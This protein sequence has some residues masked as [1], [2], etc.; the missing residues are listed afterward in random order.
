MAASHTPS[1][2][3]L[4]ALQLAHLHCLP[5]E[6][7]DIALGIAISLE[8]QAILKKLLE[9]GR[10][11]FC[12]ELNYGFYCLLKTEGF[13]VT[14]LQAQVFSDDRFGP[15]FDHMLLKVAL[16]QGPVIADVGF[17]DSFL[18]PLAINTDKQRDNGHHYLLK[19][20]AGRWTLYQDQTPQ[21]RFDETAQPLSAFSQ[22]AHWHQHS[23]RSHFTQKA[24]CSMATSNGRVTLSDKTLIK[25]QLGKRSEKPVNSLAQYHELLN[26]RFSLAIDEA[27][28]SRWFNAN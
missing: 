6:N 17:G 28:L 2:T 13:N 15:N 24:I 23:P 21:L 4:N 8:R 14:L 18:K 16:P 3:R 26:S 27:L 20:A 12:Y 22:M 10:G 19:A 7:L 5:F 11:G 9:K 1:L 25:T